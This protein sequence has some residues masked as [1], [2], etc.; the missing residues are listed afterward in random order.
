MVRVT[1]KISETM[2]MASVCQGQYP[3][4]GYLTTAC[5]P[6]LLTPCALALLASLPLREHPHEF[7][8]LTFCTC[9]FSHLECTTPASSSAQVLLPQRGSPDICT[10]YY[11]HTP[12]NCPLGTPLPYLI[13]QDFLNPHSRSASHPRT[14]VP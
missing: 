12:F 6:L 10:S 14:Q 2:T 3:S 8:L 5:G 9:Y 1:I 7:P 13:I 11:H 4:E